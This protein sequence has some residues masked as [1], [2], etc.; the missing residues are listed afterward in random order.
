MGLCAS[1]MRYLMLTG[2]KTDIE[3]QGQQINQQ[4]TVLAQESQSF[5]NKMLSM[6]APS[7]TDYLTENTQANSNSF[8]SG[9]YYY[10]GSSMTN[11]TQTDNLVQWDS[12][13]GALPTS[14]I[15]TW[16]DNGSMDANGNIVTNPSTGGG[17]GTND[18]YQLAEYNY[19][20]EYDKMNLKLSAIEQ[21]DRSL[22][23]KLKNLDTQQD[24]V[25][26]EM[27]SV[28]KVIDKNLEQV[29]KTFQ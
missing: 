7:A 18:L 27:E 25:S 19:K 14:G 17:D 15:I 21:D 3:F 23:I 11:Y 1:Q 12:S 24:A 20:L 6:H 13:K 16:Q 4:R 5:M 29:F 2:R 28:K 22:E 9:M 26:T 10:K 8:Q